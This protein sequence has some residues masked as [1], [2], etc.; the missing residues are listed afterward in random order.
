LAA[1]DGI[2]A[3]PTGVCLVADQHRLWHFPAN[4]DDSGTGGLA[5]FD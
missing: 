5:A 4:L 3:Y 1:I 2:P